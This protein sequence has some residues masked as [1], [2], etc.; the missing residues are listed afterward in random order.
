MKIIILAAGRGERLMP[1]TQNTPKPL[2]DVGNGNTLLEEQMLSI[3]ESGAI[4]EVVLVIG[5]LADQIEAKM[6]AYRDRG[7][8]IRTIYNPFWKVSNNL[9]SLWLARELMAES[10]AMVTNGDNIFTPEIFAGLAAQT[11]GIWLSVCPKTKFDSD[12]MKVKL[13]DGFVESVSKLTP[14]Q[15]ITVESPGLMMVRGEHARQL[16]VEQLEGTVRDDDS[17]NNRF[18]LE[19]FNRMW[20]K[21]VFVRPWAFESAGHWQEIDFHIDVKVMRELLVEKMLRLSTQSVL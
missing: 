8:R 6:R 16:F 21:G 14:P 2:I 1:L 12:D 5:Y 15:D 10:D 4:D 13:R 17:N 18:W 3:Q 20:S 11:D 19:V 9:L 7:F